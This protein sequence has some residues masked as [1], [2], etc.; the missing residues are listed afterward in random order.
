MS[1]GVVDDLVVIRY[2]EGRAKA[3]ERVMGARRTC[4]VCAQALLQREI[5]GY[6]V[7]QGGTEIDVVEEIE[8]FEEYASLK[9]LVALRVSIG[10]DECNRSIDTQG[11]SQ[12]SRSRLQDKSIDVNSWINRGQRT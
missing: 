4:F 8:M 6:V 7:T 9:E 2:C 3:V 11:I 5:E 1:L 10:L 12:S